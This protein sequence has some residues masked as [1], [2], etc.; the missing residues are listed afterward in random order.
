MT[1][2][3]TVGV[4]EEFQIV[5]P[6]TW[7][8]LP[9]LRIGELWVKSDSV[10]RGYWNRPKPTADAFQAYTTDTGE[11]PF[12]RT[13]DLGFVHGGKLFITGR[14]KELIIVN[15]ENHYPQD[16]EETV[17]SLSESFR[18]HY[19]AA[20][21]FDDD[22]LAVVQAV[23]RGKDIS[24]Q[25]DDLVTRIRRAVLK[26]HGVAPAYI[27]LVNPA[28]IPKTS[29]GKIQRAE[30]RRQLL[31]KRLPI[32]HAWEIERPR[33]EPR[34]APRPTVDPASRLKFRRPSS[35]VDPWA[36][37]GDRVTM[38]TTPVN[39]FAPQTAEAGPR[40]TSIWRTSAGSTGIMSQRIAPTKS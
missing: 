22:R 26:V 4:E 11:G 15:G 3:F 32:L 23:N 8:A 27:G 5:D 16:I 35:T 31:E 1:H 28:T 12:L 6:N 24:A 2:A 39:A 10:T 17:Q 7:S 20:F 13:G 38:F 37:R 36:S 18:V 25:F 21:S 40:T 14:I 29:S 19:G 34:P 9:E 30:L 33:A